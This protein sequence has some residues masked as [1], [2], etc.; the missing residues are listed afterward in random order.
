MKVNTIHIKNLFLIG[1]LLSSTTLLSQA[2]GL[3]PATDEERAEM[4][5]D[6]KEYIGSGEDIYNLTLQS[7]GEATAKVL[8]LGM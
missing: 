3:I 8:I 2:M 1:L 5:K 4:D 6:F 7:A